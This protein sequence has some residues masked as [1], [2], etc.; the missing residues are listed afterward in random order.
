MSKSNP[1]HRTE[2]YVYTEPRCI[3][4]RE[5]GRRVVHVLP[6]GTLHADRAPLA[7]AEARRQAELAQKPVVIHSRGQGM[8][9]YA[10]PPQNR[11]AVSEDAP[12]ERG[13]NPHQMAPA[14][15]RG[16]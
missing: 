10:T 11:A 13:W 8:Q 7:G 14:T 16:L 15:V 12:R 5:I 6:K 1:M 3:E 4:G 2:S 9:G